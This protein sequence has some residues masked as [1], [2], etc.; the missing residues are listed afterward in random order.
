MTEPDAFCDQ[1][2]PTTPALKSDTDNE[3]VDFAQE[4]DEIGTIPKDDGRN[5]ETVAH[6][7]GRRLPEG[8]NEVVDLS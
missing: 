5:G 4:R 6:P 1:S 2:E 3:N 8:E 7:H